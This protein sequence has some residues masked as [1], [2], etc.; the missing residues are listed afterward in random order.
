MG[1]KVRYDELGGLSTE[2]D[3]IVKEFEDAGSR[4]RDLKDAVGDPYG[5][6]ALRDAA[7]DF[8]G[9]WDDRRKALIE[10]CKTVKDHVDGVIQGFKDFDV[11]AAQGGDK[12]GK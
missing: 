3:H 11:K 12:G 2:L 6:G 10:N 7:D 9:R 8:E 5:D 4:R 1:V